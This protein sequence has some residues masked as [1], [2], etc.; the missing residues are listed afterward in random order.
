M[1][2]KTSLNPPSDLIQ[3]QPN[4]K[5]LLAVQTQDMVALQVYVEAATRVPTTNEEL[6]EKTTVD[7][8]FSE[9][10]S[11]LNANKNVKAH[12][13]TF[14]DVTFPESVSCASDIYNY[15]KKAPIFMGAVQK[16][17]DKYDENPEKYK[18]EVEQVMDNLIKDATKYGE[19]ATAV[20]NKFHQFS[21]ETEDDRSILK[22][23]HEG[24]LQK[25]NDHAIEDLNKQI[26]NAQSDLKKYQAEYDYDV[27]VAATTPT[28][29]WLGPIGFICAAAVAGTYGQRATDAL[30][31]VKRCEKEIE[32]LSSDLKKAIKLRREISIVDGSLNDILGKI[33]SAITALNKIEG[34][35]GAIADDIGNIR[36]KLKEDILD[37]PPFIASLGIEEAITNWTTVAQMA[38]EYR[39]S[40]YTKEVSIE[41]IQ[42]NPDKY[43]VPT[44]A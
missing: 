26:E 40:A 9:F 31:S 44:R 15:G 18:K 39:Q 12:C 19:K 3:T 4:G 38:N 22:P 7:D 16:I 10:A 30:N 14:R 41:E 43:K 8:D 34:A 25:L 42:K 35:W 27:T 1:P 23:I 20:K 29:A 5:K 36:D 33:N 37:V 13:V 24:F 17:Y 21:K 28:Y 6:K 2:G 11:M 32:R